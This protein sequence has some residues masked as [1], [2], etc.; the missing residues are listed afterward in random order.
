MAAARGNFGILCTLPQTST[1]EP[2][3]AA[4]AWELGPA[5]QRIFRDI[6]SLKGEINT[7]HYSWRVDPISRGTVVA[8]VVMRRT[9]A[10][11]C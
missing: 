9:R 8:N 5:K 2:D 10:T 4:N 3:V 11:E 6:N 1:E 7:A